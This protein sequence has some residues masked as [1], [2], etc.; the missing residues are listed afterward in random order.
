VTV[1]ESPPPPAV[2]VGE[3][4]GCEHRVPFRILAGPLR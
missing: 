3:M 1:E 2:P 4:G